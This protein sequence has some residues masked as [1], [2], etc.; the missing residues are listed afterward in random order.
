MRTAHI[1]FPLVFAGGDV[2][3]KRGADRVRYRI[4]RMAL[5][6]AVLV[7]DPTALIMALDE[8]CPHQFRY[9]PADRGHADFPD[10]LADLD[11]NMS[12]GAGH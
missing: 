5:S 3:V 2:R 6:A 7:V 8:P 12:T 9:S 10:A 4:D 11:V 1:G